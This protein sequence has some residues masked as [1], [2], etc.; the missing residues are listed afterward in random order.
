MKNFT[1]LKQV[2]S[3]VGLAVVGFAII[4]GVY[5]WGE[6][7]VNAQRQAAETAKA[8]SSVV[9]TVQ[10]LFLNARR[11][12]KDFLLRR[13]EK[14]IEQLNKVV[15]EIR[16]SLAQLEE[17]GV[18]AESASDLTAIGSGISTYHDTFRQVAEDVVAIGLT[19]KVGLRGKLRSAVHNVE[20]RL[21][22]MQD[23]GMLVKMLMMR[24]HEKDFLL[25]IDP[26]YI[27]RIDDRRTELVALLDAAGVTGSA[28]TEI[29]ALLDTY[30]TS[31]KELAEL[32]LALG[33]KTQ[34]LSDTFAEIE[35]VMEKVAE[36]IE[37]DRAAAV[38][39][40]AAITAQTQ[41]II[42]VVI[43]VV[44]LVAA[45]VGVLVA[46]A[47]SGPIQAMTDT[48]GELA[49]GRRDVEVPATDYRNE[50]GQMAQSV[51][52]F[53][54]SLIAAD[55]LAEEQRDA[56][57]QQVKR[58][59]KLMQRTS[60]FDAKIQE[61]LSQVGSAVTQMGQTAGHM[62][63]AS[64]NVESQSSA[65]AS[66]SAES[67]M[68]VQTVAA[69]TEELSASIVE[70]GS[71]IQ[72]ANH[73]TRSAVDQA[74]V[75]VKT[76]TDLETAVSQISEVIDLIK[77]IAEQTNLL[78]LNAT[79]EAARAGDAGKGFAVVANEVKSLSAETAKATEQIER[80]IS[81]V[82]AAT[83]TTVSSITEFSNTV[84]QVNE[85]S[86]AVAAA[87]EE[88][89]AATNE[90]SRNVE[91]AAQAVEDVNRNIQ[92]VSE[93]AK[94]TKKAAIE[95]RSASDLIGNQTEAVTTS[96]AGFLADVRSI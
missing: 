93:S 28:R 12:E 13:D 3:I 11:R 61:I 48:M 2:L 16:S 33:E 59:E 50:I 38:D 34:Q 89:T 9:Q 56:Q 86:A 53:R 41:V 36:R 79:I 49:G 44:T 45:L 72:N 37:A 63:K 81:A 51:L 14:Y 74:Q 83:G 92:G 4:G 29:D 78:A 43:V 47:I 71:Q 88:Q 84:N 46:R 19:E 54:D 15:A 26:K 1:I 60:D 22:T 70:I 18:P 27:G 87:I 67:A 69:A 7:S 73:I 65:V 52:S 20:E 80:Q 42:P 90:I 55:T 68:N 24:R 5:F 58:A 8:R 96:V 10:Y 31:F 82:Q 39:S 95:V 91:E 35:P 30:V 94:S 62:D 25:R 57:A 64:D 6:G 40:A 76:V 32:V 17:L 66:S 75:S 77:D 21:L 85:I 23:D